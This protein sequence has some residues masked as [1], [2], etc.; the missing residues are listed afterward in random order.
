MEE[1]KEEVKL[2][3]EGMRNIRRFQFN[4]RTNTSNLNLEP[5]RLIERN[6]VSLLFVRGVSVDVQQSV[7]EFG[8]RK[9]SIWRTGSHKND[10]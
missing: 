10:K 9:S 7:M 3:R 5:Q 2:K 6:R 8:A 1:D 4:R